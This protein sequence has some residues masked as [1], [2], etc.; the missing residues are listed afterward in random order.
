MRA[1]WKNQL[2]A[3]SDNTLVV[4]GCH[5]FPSESVNKN[6]F[7]ESDTNTI[8]PWKGMASYFDINVNGDINYD[9]AWC[10]PIASV[11][12]KAIEGMVAFRKGVE[13]RQ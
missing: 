9:A 4:E 8:C 13:V 2:L 10:Y 1:I 11:L 5:Y 7:Q 12:A 3:E 6:F